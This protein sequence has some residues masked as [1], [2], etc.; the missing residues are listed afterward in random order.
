[1]KR[2]IILAVIAAALLP[3][4]AFTF[5]HSS[6]SDNYISDIQSVSLADSVFSKMSVEEKILQLYIY[7]SR[8]K[9]PALLD[10]IPSG[11]VYNAMSINE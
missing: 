6:E 8:D 1:M 3:V 7:D 2:K 11:V 9:N 5:A 4:F 10:K